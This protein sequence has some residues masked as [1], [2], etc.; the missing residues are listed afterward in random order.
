MDADGARRTLG[1]RVRDY[2]AEA[3]ALFQNFAA[4]H[5]FTIERIEEP[6]V[7]LLMRVPR[8]QG[9]SFDLTLGLQNADELNIGFEGFWSYFFP[10]EKT[11]DLVNTTL[12]G[13]ALGKCRLA[14][15]R[16]FGGVVRRVL[17]Q[18]TDGAWNAIY[19][20]VSRFQLPF[21][22]T[23]ISYVYNVDARSG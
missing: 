3:E 10:F 20:A 17:E 22:G 7:E 9:L 13:I 15:Y 16:Q 14:I 12:D 11:R 19:M 21:V 18:R 23:R 1:A 5:S 8:Q 4:R 2:T 6:S